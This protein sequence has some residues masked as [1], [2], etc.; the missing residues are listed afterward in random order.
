MGGNHGFN[1]WPLTKIPGPWKWISTC[2]TRMNYTPVPGIEREAPGILH[3][4]EN[5][6]AFTKHLM[7]AT[8]GN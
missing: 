5:Q 7:A 2:K 4:Q 8:T 1:V 3:P 6:V